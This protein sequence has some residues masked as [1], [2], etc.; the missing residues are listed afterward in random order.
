MVVIRG[1]P[2]RSLEPG[3]TVGKIVLVMECENDLGRHG[4]GG[5]REMLPRDHWIKGGGAYN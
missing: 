1:L 2:V 5:E 3:S 4:G